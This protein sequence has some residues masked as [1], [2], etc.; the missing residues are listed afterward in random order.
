MKKSSSA[1]HW[2]VLV[3]VITTCMFWLVNPTQI[4]AQD[5]RPVFTVDECLET[6]GDYPEANNKHLAWPGGI[7]CSY[8][9]MSAENEEF[10][11]GKS[12]YVIYHPSP[13][14]AL[15]DLKERF[16]NDEH[17]KQFS[18]ETYNDCD[19]VDRVLLERT[20]NSFYG[21]SISISQYTNI[22]PD[23]YS[24]ER[25]YVT[26]NYN[27]TIFVSGGQFSDIEEAMAELEELETKAKVMVSQPREMVAISLEN[28]NSNSNANGN[29]NANINSNDNDNSNFNENSNENTA[30]PVDSDAESMPAEDLTVVSPEEALEEQPDAIADPGPDPQT[31]AYSNL[32]Q[33]LET[34]LAGEG[35]QSPT[36][37]QIAAGG[38]ALSTLLGG[39]LL[40]NLLSG[41]PAEASLAA[42]SAWQNQKPPQVPTATAEPELPEKPDSE[43]ETTQPEKTTPPH[44]IPLTAEL[45]IDQ[46]PPRTPASG[47]TT[48]ESIVRNIRDIKDLD[49]AVKQT[50]QDFEAFIDQVPAS[51]R[52]SHEWQTLVEPKLDEVKGL[53]KSGELD[54][55]RTWMDRV[56]TLIE[57]RNDV[58]R[59]LAYLPSDSQEA[60]VWTERTLKTLGHFA[61][62]AYQGLVIEPA[63]TAGGAILPSE[64]SDKWG[65]HMDELGQ[66]LSDVAQQVGELPRQG[67]RL[68]THGELQE[69][70]A[71]MLQSS[72]PVLHQD[73]QEIG[74]LN[75]RD[76]PVERPDF[77]GKGTKK[78][79][80]LWNNS[81]GK[82]FD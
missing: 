36:P 16:L 38:V 2:F 41:T 70:A 73:A 35:I 50:N 59:D 12:L 32:Y 63:K 69:N 49:D 64:L 53:I 45:P 78:V 33:E 24:L 57:L 52:N 75:Q 51:V 60:I 26:G 48:E 17:L 66:A 30:L 19:R 25:R 82:I 56:E 58:E 18:C 62:D 14:E 43:P 15:D 11:K 28:D 13:E 4:Y 61:S 79:S 67:A 27:V 72:D 34:F 23:F 20:E 5:E 9:L 22:R 81:L 55:T 1:N 21:Y 3:F 37:G 40:L 71:E 7:N 46:P 80:E 65:E 77:W 44:V 76:T 31:T 47:E 6:Q 54:Q 10:L 74:E 39:W 42:I 29:E 68:F 8:K